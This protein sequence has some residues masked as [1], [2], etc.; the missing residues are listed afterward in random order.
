MGGT[1]AC[2][3]VVDLWLGL[4]ERAFMVARVLPRSLKGPQR[5]R[6][7]WGSAALGPETL[8]DRSPLLAASYYSTLQDLLLQL[9]IHWKVRVRPPSTQF[10]NLVCKTSDFFLL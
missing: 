8:G 9:L 1:Y 2:T 6:T 5:R 3:V 4:L 10:A 7:T